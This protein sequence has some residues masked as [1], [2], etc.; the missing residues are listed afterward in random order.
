MVFI[1]FKAFIYFIYILK[2]LKDKYSLLYGKEAINLN[3]L[4]LLVPKPKIDTLQQIK[5]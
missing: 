4:F 1:K 2:Q 3:R 5:I